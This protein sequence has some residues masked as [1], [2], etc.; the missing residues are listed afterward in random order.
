MPVY[1]HGSCRVSGERRRVYCWVCLVMLSRAC[2]LGQ[3]PLTSRGSRC[4]RPWDHGVRTPRF[5][6]TRTMEST[7]GAGRVSQLATRQQQNSQ[8]MKSRRV[9]ERRPLVLAASPISLRRLESSCAL[10]SRAVAHGL[11]LF[12]AHAQ[13]HGTYVPNAIGEMLHP[14]TAPSACCTLLFQGR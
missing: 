4:K 11:L 2:G 1:S 5:L 12:K 8:S 7:C 13:R 9:G 10:A 6:F 14:N 3:R